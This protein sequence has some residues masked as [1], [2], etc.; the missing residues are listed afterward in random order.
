MLKDN[1]YW[2]EE[3][4]VEEVIGRDPDWMVRS[5]QGLLL[6]CFLILFT[7]IYIVKYPDTIRASTILT[8]Q[9]QPAVIKS[10]RGGRLLH[11]NII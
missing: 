2:E 4:P 1:S 6:L 9:V 8:T 3:K 10:K 11:L 7:V 5:G